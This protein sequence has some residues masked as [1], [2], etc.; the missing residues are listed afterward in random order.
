MA[1]AYVWWIEDGSEG[2]AS[3]GQDLETI[4]VHS[5]LAYPL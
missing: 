2:L 3:L 4:E 5:F 1:M